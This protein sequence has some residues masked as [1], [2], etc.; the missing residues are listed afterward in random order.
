MSAIKSFTAEIIG[1]KED[2]QMSKMCVVTLS[3]E[4]NR[5]NQ[6]IEEAILEAYEQNGQSI[7]MIKPFFKAGLLRGISSVK[8]GFSLYPKIP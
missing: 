5:H 1:K 2:S 8:L 7:D 4:V 6:L 3:K